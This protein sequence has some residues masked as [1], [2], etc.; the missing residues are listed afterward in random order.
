MMQALVRAARGLLE[1]EEVRL[2]E[3]ALNIIRGLLA[4]AGFILARLGLATASPS[5]SLPDIS[6]LFFSLPP[7]LEWQLLGR[8]AAEAAVGAALGLICA[9]LVKTTWKV[10][11]LFFTALGAVFGLAWYYGVIT[12]NWDVLWSLMPTASGENL[13]RWAPYLSG[14]GTALALGLWKLKGGEVWLAW[15]L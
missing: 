8:A 9:Y 3:R 12:V 1:R 4:I 7:G 5:F 6:L 11:A 14:F 15:R 13:L 2:L 10:M